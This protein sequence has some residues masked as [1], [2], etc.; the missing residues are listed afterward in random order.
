ME[1]NVT[2]SA[3]KSFSVDRG[4]SIQFF[5]INNKLYLFSIDG[6]MSLSTQIVVEDPPNAD[7]TDFDT[8]FRPNGNKPLPVQQ[9]PFAA[10]TLPS[11]KKIFKRVNG[12]QSALSSGANTVIFTIPYAWAKISGLEIIGGEVLDTVS[13]SVL[14]S[15]TGTY[16]TIPDYVLNQFGFT[17][18]VAKDFYEQ[19]SEFDADLYQNMQIKIVYTS[20]SAKTVGINLILV[21]V[22]S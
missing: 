13:L 7:Y 6:P 1:L 5:E 21:E 8:N 22:K 12:I 2:W 18:N 14:D 3:L 20:V 10:K 16:S 15:T 17:V 9:Q 11:G 19:K 4:I